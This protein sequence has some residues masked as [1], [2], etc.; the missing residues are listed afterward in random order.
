MMKTW[1]SDWWNS[2]SSWSSFLSSP[3]TSERDRGMLAIFSKKSEQENPLKNDLALRSHNSK[4]NSQDKCK[5]HLCLEQRPNA[6]NIQWVHKMKKQLQQ[7]DKPTCWG[8]LE[9]LT[10]VLT[11]CWMCAVV[12]YFL[13]FQSVCMIFD[14]YSLFKTSGQNLENT[15]LICGSN[16]LPLGM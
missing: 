14:A 1:A 10:F 8:V 9:P 3:N 7:G 11:C 2:L 4:T 5:L 13:L 16:N 15:S 6:S 12:I